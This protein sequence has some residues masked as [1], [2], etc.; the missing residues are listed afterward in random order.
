MKYGKQF[1]LTDYRVQFVDL[2]EQTAPVATAESLE[3]C[4]E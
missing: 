3:V 4:T 2:W 1:V